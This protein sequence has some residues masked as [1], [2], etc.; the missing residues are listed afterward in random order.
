MGKFSHVMEMIRPL[1]V[2][3]AS[4]LGISSVAFCG[5]ALNA[6]PGFLYLVDP[7]MYASFL[8]ALV[9]D[10][11]AAI[12]VGR[13]CVMLVSA[14]LGQ[15][16]VIVN[17]SDN[18]SR[19]RTRILMWSVMSRSPIA[20]QYASIGLSLALFAFLYLGWAGAFAYFMIAGILCFGG[21]FLLFRFKRQI[22][23]V[24]RPPFDSEELLKLIAEKKVSFTVSTTIAALAFSLGVTRAE[25]IFEQ[26]G[27]WICN[28]TTSFDGAVL[29]RSLGGLVVVLHDDEGDPQSVKIVD[30]KA[31]GFSLSATR[32]GCH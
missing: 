29:G 21:F 24:V 2:V 5:F 15:M 32:A 3:A 9:F 23:G 10:L 6:L 1:I 7:G 20:L 11:V 16:S 28:D 17:R 14:L 4:I 19:R 22:L 18:N 31:E 8:A 12:A 26:E 30:P 25:V 27:V 13:L